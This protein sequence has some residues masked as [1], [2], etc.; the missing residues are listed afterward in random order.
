M[1]LIPYIH[2]YDWGKYGD[3]SKVAILFKNVNPGF[4]I[5]PHKPYAELWM[6]THVNG[7][8]LVKHLKRTLHDVISGQPDYLGSVVQDK[9]GNNLP[10][11]LKVLSIKKALSIQVHPSK[12]NITINL[13]CFINICGLLF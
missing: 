9:F 6:G 2:S 10:Y 11:L 3:T 8:S 7:P 13:F 12:V 1:E 4:I 5:E